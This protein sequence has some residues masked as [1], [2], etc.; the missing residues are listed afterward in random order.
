VGLQRLRNLEQDTRCSLLVDHY[1][2][3]WAA[4]W[5]VRAH[6]RASL[7]EG[8]DERQARSLL[9]DRFPP[10]RARPSVASVLVLVADGVTGWA[11]G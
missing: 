2:D 4:L 9:A 8:D 3:D 11:E 7:A 6:G 10:Y 5:W 1:D